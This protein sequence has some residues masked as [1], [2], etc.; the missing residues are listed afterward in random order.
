MGNASAI[1]A[2]RC[3]PAIR[4]TA[5]MAATRTHRSS[6]IGPG[7]A[8][9]FKMQVAL[10]VQIGAASQVHAWLPCLCFL[11]SGM[12][13]K[14]GA[15]ANTIQREYTVRARTC[16]DVSVSM[17]TW[18]CSTTWLSVPWCAS[19]RCRFQFTHNNIASHHVHPRCLVPRLL[20]L[21]WRRCEGG[22][23]LNAVAAPVLCCCE[24]IAVVCRYLVH[25]LGRDL[26]QQLPFGTAIECHRM[27]PAGGICTRTSCTAPQVFP[28]PPYLSPSTLTLVGQAMGMYG[29]R[30]QIGGNAITNQHGLDATVTP[31]PLAAPALAAG[32]LSAPLSEP[33]ALSMCEG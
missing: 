1:A 13:A 26:V 21:Q 24:P 10:T 2:G 28:A 30:Q 15:A 27:P 18:H 16:C 5:A 22:H 31:L 23:Q 6:P 33:H 17:L 20:V 14:S 32:Q 11:V 9:R 4:R 7:G 19:F 29:C 25:A 8:C 12:I 3:G